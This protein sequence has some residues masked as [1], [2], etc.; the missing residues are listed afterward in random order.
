MP[1]CRAK[2]GVAR[3]ALY[4]SEAERA[5]LRDENLRLLAAIKQLQ[6]DNALLHDK[7]R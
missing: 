4:R 1:M 2:E 6:A 7:L 3:S 5:G